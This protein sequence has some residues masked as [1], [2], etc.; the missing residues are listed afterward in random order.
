[1]RTLN[2]DLSDQLQT[3]LYLPAISEPYA[4]LAIKDASEVRAMPK[5]LKPR[6]LNFFNEQSPL[7]HIPAALYS[8]GVV[9]KRHDPKPCMVSTRDR[10]KTDV[11]GDSGGYQVISGKISGDNAAA[12]AGLYHWQS[13]I[14]DYGVTFDVPT[15]AIADPRNSYKSFNECLSDTLIFLEQYQR[16]NE[17]SDFNLLNV[18]QGRNQQ[19][20]DDWFEAVKRYKFRGWAFAGD[21]KTNWYLVIRR[22]FKLM[23]QELFHERNFWIHFLGTGDLQTAVLLT[24]LR[25]CIRKFLGNDIFH[26]SF[27]TSTAFSQVGKMRTVY[28]GYSL[29]KNRFTFVKSTQ[30]PPDAIEH[31]GSSKPFPHPTSPIGQ[32]LTM[33]DIYVK[34]GAYI[35]CR[36]DFLADEM[37]K[38]HNLYVL[39]SAIIAA[40][41][42]MKK[43]RYE[44]FE[45]IPSNIYHAAQA[46]REIFDA[47]HPKDALEKYKPTL[48]RAS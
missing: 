47:H 45:T 17:G 8:A 40:N 48:D 27:D 2:P 31:V 13:S 36:W 4:Q 33:G 43:P 46:M 10:A 38:N 24:V 15:K 39:M 28:S 7:L 20:T 25:D 32:R 29:D 21:M 14:C 5:G 9:T 19:E 35:K 34:G 18:L 30:M 1:M 12:R 22:I 23:E 16:L 3:A 11:L 26:L 41:E 6:D 44:T 37:L 42:E